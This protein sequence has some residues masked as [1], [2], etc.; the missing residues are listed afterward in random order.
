MNVD[1]VTVNLVMLD[2]PHQVISSLV[3]VVTLV[4][5]NHSQ[6]KPSVFSVIKEQ[7]S[8]SLVN[9]LAPLVLLVMRLVNLVK[10]TATSV[11]W[12]LLQTTPM[13][14]PALVVVQTLIK[15][16]LVKLHARPAQLSPQLKDSLLV[17]R[18]LAVFV[19]RATNG[20]PR[21]CSVLSV[22]LVTN[23]PMVFLLLVVLVSIRLTLD[24]V[25]VCHVA[26]AHSAQVQQMKTALSVVT[27]SINPTLAK[28]PVLI[29]P[30][31]PLTHLRV[32]LL[33]HPV[34]AMLVT[35]STSTLFSVL[36]VTA[37]SLLLQMV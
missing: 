21:H 15:T 25:F 5:A 31:S 30:L 18:F 9:P 20:T 26:A 33:S 12:V 8:H 2:L 3:F 24:K 14:Y 22:N 23:A 11:H 13:L 27:T 4:I 34:C 35:Y 36:G 7:H 6:V 16:S 1:N 10:P 17:P 37:P 29:V 28:L 32:R 19:M